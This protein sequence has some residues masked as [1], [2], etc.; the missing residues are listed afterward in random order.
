MTCTFELANKM[1]VINHW[2]SQN[3]KDVF[4][5]CG[6]TKILKKDFEDKT[7]S[8]VYI[9]NQSIYDN[10]TIYTIKCKISKYCFD[11]KY[12]VDDIYCWV[13]T[14]FD[15]NNKQIIISRLLNVNNIQEFIQLSLSFF[16]K[17]ISNVEFNDIS[18]EF[19][20]DK[21]KNVNYRLNTLDFDVYDNH[22]PFNPF[23]FKNE[24]IKKIMKYSNVLYYSDIYNNEINIVTKPNAN[25][26]YFGNTNKMKIDVEN[27]EYKDKI[28]KHFEESEIEKKINTSNCNIKMLYFRVLPKNSNIKLYLEGVFNIVHTSKT[29]PFICLKTQFKTLYKVN[30]SSIMNIDETILKRFTENEIT[31]LEKNNIQ[32]HNSF[33]IFTMVLSNDILYNIVL[34]ANGSYRV[35][36]VIKNNVNIDIEDIY[37]TLD[38]INIITKQCNDALY[39]IN[40][41]TNIFN[42]ENIEIIEYTT[43]NV[44][45]LKSPRLSLEN[46]ESNLKTASFLFESIKISKKQIILKYKNVNNYINSDNISNFIYKNSELAKSDLVSKLADMFN[47]SESEAM[48]EYEDK[49]HNIHLHKVHKGKN[50]FAKRYYQTGV[51]VQVDLISSVSLR[52]HTFNTQHHDNIKYILNYI[53]NVIL[54]KLP[55]Y[56]NKKI[57]SVDEISIENDDELSFNEILDNYDNDFDLE[58]ILNENNVDIN[59]ETDINDLIYNEEDDEEYEEEDDENNIEENNNKIH[60]YTTFVLN[61]LYDADKKLFKWENKAVKNYSGR[62]GAVDYRQPVVIT[63]QEKDKIDKEQPNSYTGYVKSGSTEELKEKHFYICPKIWCT[64]S[65]V[66]I[67]PEEYI[68]NGN[69]CPRNESG[70]FFPISDAKKNY[71]IN[72]KGIEQHWPRFLE[73]KNPS[74][75]SLPCCGKTK[76][77]DT[78]IDGEKGKQS[79]DEK[80]HNKY[81]ANLDSNI[82]LD[83][84]K[85]AILPN[86]LNKLLKNPNQC[87]GTLDTKHSCFV[88]TGMNVYT[89]QSLFS[90][91]KKILKIDIQKHILEHMTL[92]HYMFLNNGNTVKV[93][94][95]TNDR[96]KIYDKIDFIEFKESFVSN[97]EYIRTFNLKDIKKELLSI[98]EFDSK[99]DIDISMYNKIIREF[100]IYKSYINFKTYISTDDIEKSINDI[101]HMLTFKWLNPN[102]VK[103][104]V[105]EIKENEV[106]VLNPQYFHFGNYVNGINISQRV[107]ILIM[108]GN[109]YEYVSHIFTKKQLYNEISIFE[110]NDVNN[111]ITQ[112]HQID[113][114]EKH[115]LINNEAVTKYVLGVNLKLVGLIIKDKYFVPSLTYS[116]IDFDMLKN[117]SFIYSIDIDK[118]EID[119]DILK[120]YNIE[121]NEI[122]KNIL[123]RNYTSKTN[124]E[125]FINENTVEVHNKYEIKLYEICKKILKSTKIYNSYNVLIHPINPMSIN[126]KKYILR[127]ILDNLDIQNNE[128]YI[129]DLIYKQLNTIIKEYENTNNRINID[130]ILLNE[131]DMISYKLIDI[132][133]NLVNHIKKINLTF[134]DFNFTIEY[135]KL[136]TTPETDVVNNG[137]KISSNKIDIT[138]NTFKVYLE[139]FNLVDEIL[140]NNDILHIFENMNSKKFKEEYENSIVTDYTKDKTKLIHILKMNPNVLI[141][142]IKQSSTIT[143][144]SNL[145]N[146]DNY[147]FSIYEL[148]VLANINNINVCVFGRETKRIPNGVYIL[149]S[150]N[151]SN[152]YLCLHYTNNVD[153]SKDD[154][155]LMIND[156]TTYIFELNDFGENFV[157]LLKLFT[158]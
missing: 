30:K 13:K 73:G 10:D 37:N 60:D 109:K 18:R 110:Y 144:I 96:S 69:K 139:G 101:Y 153:K 11:L 85:Y 100:L 84:G 150:K 149:K 23:H 154:L 66:S 116:E 31:N 97:K 95:N 64:V 99:T 40:K 112:L 103:F 90:V 123:R 17:K 119:E 41:N 49:K 54:V 106:Y 24:S 143:E 124:L 12:G 82:L 9:I 36:F 35:Q 156:K 148:S 48:N 8:N 46:I 77:Y 19:L 147:Y 6:D 74:G 62:C 141:H 78:I 72:S 16:G 5:F 2:N 52:I 65:R 135:F 132:K 61:K 26:I 114:N 117:Q 25:E 129:N 87:I 70:L 59:I 136:N 34:A 121:L 107:S 111:I 3:T 133:Q 47:M 108:N 89:N 27:I 145:I 118:Y 134:D 76:T 55:K 93:F 138:P 56:K 15:D 127:K 105:L 21:L 83:D 58:D 50:V 86:I 88:R 102:N 67:T 79:K 122:Q 98:D 137:Y 155:R 128:I 4:I 71:F 125:I 43:H 28:L 20:E 120:K 115:S 51:T 157:K 1:Y 44:C 146:K 142:G 151:I 33:I 104:L 57:D 42:D 94:M 126:E 45:T 53:L 158:N 113:I 131:N 7:T 38:N 39:D 140:S 130:E 29:N 32:K 81:I 91:L 14:K 152:K 92:I 75:K 80:N 68:K 22:I 63:K